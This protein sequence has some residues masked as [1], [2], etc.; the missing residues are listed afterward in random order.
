MDSEC[1]CPV[2]IEVTDYLGA[3]M[4]VQKVSLLNGENNIGVTLE[5][6]PAGNYFIKIL[7]EDG[8]GVLQVQKI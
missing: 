2:R 4:K 7:H 8:F 1:S 3:V 5:N 6:I